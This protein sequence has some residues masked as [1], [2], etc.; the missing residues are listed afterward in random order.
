M[1]GLVARMTSST[2]PESTRDR[3]FEMRSCSGPMPCRGEIAPWSTWK[4]PLKCLVF[5]IA[6]ML[7][8]SSTTQTRRWLRVAL[9]QYTQGS[10]S[11]MLLHTEQRRRLALT[12]RTATARASASS[13]L[14]RRMWKARR[15]ALFAPTPGSFFSSSIRRDMGSA[16]LDMKVG[17]QSVFG[18]VYSNSYECLPSGA[19]MMFIL[20]LI[21]ASCPVPESGATL[22][23]R[24]GEFLVMMPVWWREKAP[25]FFSPDEVSSV[26]VKVS[27]AT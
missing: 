9:V 13:S 6:A 18:S 7:V 11:V 14:E 5:S 10:T 8:G 2:L 27:M 19:M 4:T 24:L 23:D 16:N 17:S 15:W 22:M 20:P 3:R 26:P 1:V 12:S 25:D 21:P